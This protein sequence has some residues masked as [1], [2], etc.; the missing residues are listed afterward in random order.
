MWYLYQIL[1]GCFIGTGAI[2]RFSDASEASLKKKMMT[3]INSLWPSDANWQHR[4]GWTLTQVVTC[5]PTHQ[6]IT[7]T[8]VDLSLVGICGMKDLSG[9][10]EVTPQTS[11]DVGTCITIWMSRIDLQTPNVYANFNCKQT[12]LSEMGPHCVYAKVDKV[13]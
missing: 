5:C 2:V 10:N 13:E 12:T 3:D 4:S 8:N 6:N 11:I 7:S 9:A 1:Q